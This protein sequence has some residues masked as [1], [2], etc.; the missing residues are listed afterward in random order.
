M[1]MANAIAILSAL[2]V[3]MAWCFSTG[4]SVATVLGTHPSVSSCSLHRGRVTHI[5]VNK[6][7]IIGSDNGL[8]PGRH[9]ANIWTDAGILLI[10]PLETNFSEILSGIHTFS[11]K[12]MH[13]KMLS[14]KCQ[15]F[16][17][18]LNVLRVKLLWS[19]RQTYHTGVLN[20]KVTHPH[21]SM[22]HWEHHQSKNVLHH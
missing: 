19:L 1:K 20:D 10:E 6:L 17:L 8:S 12:K 21:T 3:L 11:F 9:Q 15:P 14:G 4:A 2:W 13:L 16:Y 7:T 18:G 5:C 22:P